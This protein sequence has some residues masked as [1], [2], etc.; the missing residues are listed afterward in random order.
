MVLSLFSPVSHQFY[1]CLTSPG[2][3]ISNDCCILSF[4]PSL[5]YG[6]LIVLSSI[7]LSLSLISALHCSSIFDSFSPPWPTYLCLCHMHVHIHGPFSY[8]LFAQAGGINGCSP[9]HEAALCGSTAVIRLL[10][11]TF[12]NLN[13]N[14]RTEGGPG[15]TPLHLAS[16]Q[17]HVDAVI[18]LVESGAMLSAVDRC[19]RTPKDVALE[20][21]N[22]QIVHIIRT[23]GKYLFLKYKFSNVSLF[24]ACCYECVYV[25]L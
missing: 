25:K 17:N 24:F 6:F 19:W 22:D 18:A 7:S 5:S 12:A 3:L 23:F 20:A 13:L 15:S 1:V 2:Y 16:Q 11:S 14:I 4:S 21:G 10:V 8:C 9:L